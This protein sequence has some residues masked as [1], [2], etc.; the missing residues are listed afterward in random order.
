[1]SSFTTI[2]GNLA[3]IGSAFGT[4]AAVCVA[5]WGNLF[6][7]W[8]LPPRLDLDLRDDNGT[9]AVSTVRGQAPAIARWYHLRVSNRQRWSPIKKTRVYLLKVERRNVGGVWYSDWNGE[10]P[11]Y[12]RHSDVYGDTRDFGFPG[13]CDLCVI[14]EGAPLSLKPVVATS[15]I[16]VEFAPPVELKL[17]LQARGL[18]ADSEIL[19]VVLRWDGVWPTDRSQMSNHMV[20]RKAQGNSKRRF[21]LARRNT[22]RARSPAKEI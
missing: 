14:A 5:L 12:W 15:D 1:M 18:E 20:V 11:I 19:E 8:I 6:R 7:R 3:Q 2:F 9:D 22:N 4:F 21:P 17:S 10:V 16:P 13:D